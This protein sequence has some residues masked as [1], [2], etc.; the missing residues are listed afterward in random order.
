MWYKQTIRKDYSFTSLAKAHLWPTQPSAKHIQCPPKHIQCPHPKTARPFYLKSLQFN[1][2]HRLFYSSQ[3]QNLSFS[4]WYCICL[5][6]IW[7]RLY[8]TIGYGWRQNQ[9]AKLNIVG[10]D[11]PGS[12]QQ[13]LDPTIDY[14]TSVIV[15]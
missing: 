12:N 1:S 14:I 6:L 10:G 13:D 15:S 7:W 3:T 2:Q 4:L 11:L 5:V 9:E 8:W